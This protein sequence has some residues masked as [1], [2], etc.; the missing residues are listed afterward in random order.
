MD[1]ILSATATV[2]YSQ[3]VGVTKEHEVFAI[4]SGFIGLEA[5]IPYEFAIRNAR[6]IGGRVY[7]VGCARS[8]IRRT[9]RDQWEMLS[10]GIQLPAQDEIKT[11]R[12]QMEFLDSAGFD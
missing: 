8:V 6:N 7:V 5:S 11:V 4:G 2:P 10:K 1:H 9:D 12:E 3:Y